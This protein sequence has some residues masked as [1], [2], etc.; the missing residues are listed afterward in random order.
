IGSCRKGIAMT[1]VESQP[2]L[3]VIAEPSV[4]LLGRQEIYEDALAD[5]LS[6]HDVKQWSTDTPVAGEK[7]IE[8]AG[9]VC[10]M[11]FQRPRPGGNRAYIGHLLE[12]G[13]GSVLEHAVFNLLITGVSRSLTHELV[14]HRAGFGYSQLSQRFVDE[15]ACEFVEPGPIADDPEL[16]K[17]WL[18]TV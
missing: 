10:Y 16:H 4:Y 14:R 17:L 18:S 8:T 9:R 1:D 5:F 6:E 7:L 12:V 11:S 13:H 2:A 15:S 3:Q